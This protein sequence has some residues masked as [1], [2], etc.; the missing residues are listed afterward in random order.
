MSCCIFSR[1]WQNFLPV[2]TEALIPP[3]RCA[4]CS[5]NGNYF[6]IVL[7]DG[8]QS[9]TSRFLGSIRSEQ[10]KKLK[11]MSPAQ[12]V[13]ESVSI[14]AEMSAATKVITVSVYNCLFDK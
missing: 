4:A 14:S 9:V 8:G 13:I 7:G 1:F 11:R 3:V 10:K 12:V 6:H 2:K 5:F